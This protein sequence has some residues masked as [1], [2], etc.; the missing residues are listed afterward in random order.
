MSKK[1]TL[2]TKEISRLRIDE[3]VARYLANGG[4]VKRFTAQDNKG[5]VI[6]KRTKQ[7]HI[8]ALKRLPVGRG[9]IR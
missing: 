6:K 5:A 3:D 8:D 2:T 7:E 1:T 9:V 4:K